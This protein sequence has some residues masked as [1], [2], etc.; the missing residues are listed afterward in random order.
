MQITYYKIGE[1]VYP[2]QYEVAFAIKMNLGTFR[3]RLKR[4]GGTKNIDLIDLNGFRIQIVNEV[5]SQ[6]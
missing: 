5:I 6:L 2:H 1:Q 3:S 4:A